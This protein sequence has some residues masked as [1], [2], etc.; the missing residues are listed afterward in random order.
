MP[1]EQ[2]DYLAFLGAAA[3]SFCFVLVVAALSLRAQGRAKE[4]LPL[5]VKLL[6]CLGA[7]GGGAF[8]LGQRMQVTAGWRAF[9]NLKPLEI[10]VLVVVLGCVAYAIRSAAKAVSPQRNTPP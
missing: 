2:R 3:I 8:W 7:S 1:L 9:L 5:L 4:F 10:V 6:V